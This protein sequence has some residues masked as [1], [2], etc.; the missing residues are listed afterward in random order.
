MMVKFNFIIPGRLRDSFSGLG[1]RDGY[2]RKTDCD[3]VVWRERFREGKLSVSP[4]FDSRSFASNS[5]RR[6]STLLISSPIFAIC[7]FMIPTFSS[8]SAMACRLTLFHWKMLSRIFTS[9]NSTKERSIFAFPVHPSP[10][11]RCSQGETVGACVRK[12]VSPPV[13]IALSVLLLLFFN[14]IISVSFM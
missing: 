11:S 2:L 9:S 7:D 12:S 6:I 13:V 5:F 4:L 8:V 1:V 14:M 10:P 3:R